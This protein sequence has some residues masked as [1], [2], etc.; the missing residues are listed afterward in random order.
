V[1]NDGAGRVK[2]RVPRAEAPARTARLVAELGDALA[3]LSLEDPPIEDV[4][5]RVFSGE[6]LGAGLD[7]EVMAR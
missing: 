3:D 1:A 6:H 7:R 5:D 4:I 2:I